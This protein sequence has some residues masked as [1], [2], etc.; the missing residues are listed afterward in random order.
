MKNAKAFIAT[1]GAWGSICLDVMAW[2][3]LLSGTSA[4]QA[5]CGGTN[6]QT[7]GGLAGYNAAISCNHF[8]GYTWWITFYN[9][10]FVLAAIFTMASGNMSRFRP[11]LIGLGAIAAMQAMVCANTFLSMN[12]LPIDSE[13]FKT[14]ARVTVA[15]AVIKAIAT[16]LFIIFA[17]IR[18]EKNTWIQETTQSTQKEKGPVGPPPSQNPL[19]DDA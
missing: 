16:L 14:R 6:V 4:M 19:E 17:G 12:Q 5:S 10:G 15:G 8:F 18:D 2:V 13:T 3:L 1:T 7:V 11:G 9:L